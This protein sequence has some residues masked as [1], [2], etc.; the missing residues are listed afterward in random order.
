[1]LREGEKY[2]NKRL[3]TCEN[4]ASDMQESHDLFK[5]LNPY[6]WTIFHKYMRILQ[7]N[8]MFLQF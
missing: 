3:P 4:D 7:V 1:M 2:I 5:P 6:F 8:G